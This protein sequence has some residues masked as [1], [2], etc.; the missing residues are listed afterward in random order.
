MPMS[1]GFI[2]MATHRDR[3]TPDARALIDEALSLGVSNIG[4][5]D[6]G[7]PPAELKELAK[8]IR[9]GGARVFFELVSLD[10]ESEMRS[11][12]A[13]ADFDVDW[14]LGGV[15]A[16][17][18]API[19]KAAGIAYAPF[20]G[21]VRGHP[22]VLEGSVEQIVASAEALC[23]LEGVCGLDLLAF[24][25][26]GDPVAVLRAVVQAVDV[27]VIVAGSIDSPARIR[28]VLAS[29]A[30]GFT[31]GSSAIS[32]E[33]PAPARD[34]ASQIRAIQAAAMAGQG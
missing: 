21:S 18:V 26:A 5:K 19:A 29:G 20:P 12:R 17:E 23:A 8:A 30:A 34:F 33:F 16:S 2:F 25:H 28:A 1:L 22:S 15:Q 14:L 7:L 32:G 6:I 4:F 9:S 3:T 27:P 24:R 11:A 13:A 10:P 31:V